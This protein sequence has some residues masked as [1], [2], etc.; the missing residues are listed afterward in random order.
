MD[1]LDSFISNLYNTNEQLIEYLTTISKEYTVLNVPILG[2]FYQQEF[3]MFYDKFVNEIEEICKTYEY[4]DKRKNDIMKQRK[5][6]FAYWHK[7]KQLLA[8]MEV[9]K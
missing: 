7:C 2:C 8:T 1:K 3:A 5:A 4:V 6:Q 9:D